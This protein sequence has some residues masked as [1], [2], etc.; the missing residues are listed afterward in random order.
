MAQGVG[1]REGVGTEP[2]RLMIAT[3]CHRA[4][5]HVRHAASLFRTA[6]LAHQ[7]GCH[8][9]YTTLGSTHLAYARNLLVAR[10]LETGFSHLL[11]ID[12]D[13]SWA[14]DG[15]L[16]LLAHGR[17]VV[18]GCYSDRRGHHQ[19]GWS[20][21]R[22]APDAPKPLVEVDWLGTGFL[23]LSRAVMERMTAAHPDGQFAFGVDLSQGEDK[24]WCGRWRALGGRVFCDPSIALVHH[25]EMAFPQPWMVEP[26]PGA[27]DEG[28]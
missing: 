8:V 13:I 28:G 23:M 4:Q 12:D 15:P 19:V 20:N 10:A 6:Q 16:R 14:P 11:F 18:G 21:P 22:P 1:G 26:P 7:A 2:A 17:E 25:G 3:P 5:V 24:V 27:T 9:E